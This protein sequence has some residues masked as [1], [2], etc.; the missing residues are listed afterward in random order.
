[1]ILRV[2]AA[3]AVAASACAVPARAETVRV[4]AASSLAEAF[5]EIA[6]AFEK[7]NP[8][9]SVELNLGGSQR[10]RTQIEHGAP[11]DVFASAD[12][13]HAEALQRAGLLGPTQVFARN[14]LAVAVPARGAVTRLHDLARPGTRVVVASP[15]VPVGRYTAQALAKLGASG[16]YGDGFPS[17]VQANVVSEEANVRAVLAKIALGEADAG[18]VYATDVAA[19]GGKVRAIE[20]PDRH[21]VIAEYPIGLVTRA[22]APQRA[23][24]A[25]VA[26]VLGGEGQAAL[27]RHGFA[28]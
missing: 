4:S 6:R 13:V 26:L 20:I 1:M 5:A 15:A 17:R 18:V 23:A 28:R 22:G 8:G 14:R 10:L 3:V 27:R 25:F 12:A 24:R 19:A 21:N 7:A 11:V 16:L 2:V 9:A